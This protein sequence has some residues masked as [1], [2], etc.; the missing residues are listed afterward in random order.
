MWLVSCNDV[1]VLNVPV[2]SCWTSVTVTQCL[3]I[4]LRL[5]AVESSFVCIGCSG[6]V[7]GCKGERFRNLRYFF[8]QEWPAVNGADTYKSC[9]TANVWICHPV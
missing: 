1:L 9:S 3:H 6:L 4:N 7:A 8:P 5:L 2:F